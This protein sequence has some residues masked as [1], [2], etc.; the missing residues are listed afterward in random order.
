[1]HFQ[2]CHSSLIANKQGYRQLGEGYFDLRALYYFCE[3]LSRHMQE[4][5]VNLLDQ[6]FDQVIDKQ[7]AAFQLKKCKLFW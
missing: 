3:R 1:V 4:T 5:G 2:I 6:A 7:I